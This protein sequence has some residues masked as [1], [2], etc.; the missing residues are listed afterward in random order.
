MPSTGRH[1]E[2]FSQEIVPIHQGSEGKS[3]SRPCHNPHLL[4]WRDFPASSVGAYARGGLCVVRLLYHPTGAREGGD[5]RPGERHQAFCP[6]VGRHWSETSGW[7]TAGTGARLQAGKRP[8]LERDFKLANGRHWS[9]TS[10]SSTRG[11]S[12]C[13]ALY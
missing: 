3:L 8:A 9:K 6:E 10:R 12:T 2:A 4:A 11:F 13:S 5:R 1:S 7:E